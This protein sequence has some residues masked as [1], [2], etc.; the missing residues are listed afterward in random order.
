NPLDVGCWMLDV[1]YFLTPPDFGLWTL[2]FGL[3]VATTGACPKCGC[4]RA[5]ASNRSI[6]AAISGS[7]VS[8]S[9]IKMRGVLVHRPIVHHREKRPVNSRALIVVLLFLVHKIRVRFISPQNPDAP[10]PPPLTATASHSRFH[11]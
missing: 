7:V 10:A 3:H 5:L 1:G 2:D 6:S 8:G 9:L 4:A 11:K